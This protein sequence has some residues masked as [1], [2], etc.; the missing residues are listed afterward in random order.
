[1]TEN[2]Y[3]SSC[4]EVRCNSHFKQTS[5]FTVSFFNFHEVRKKYTYK[6]CLINRRFWMWIRQTTSNQK[7]CVIPFNKVMVHREYDRW[8]LP[9]HS[10]TVVSVSTVSFHWKQLV[11]NLNLILLPLC[12]LCKWTGLGIG[13]KISQFYIVMINAVTGLDSELSRSDNSWNRKDIRV[14]RMNYSLRR[15]AA[16]SSDGTIL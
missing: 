9:T 13:W 15:E 4:K 1:M 5:I 14:R 7:I 8:R 6:K 3:S 10:S 12:D 16:L 11:M 2:C